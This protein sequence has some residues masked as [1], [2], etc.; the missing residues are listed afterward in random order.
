MTDTPTTPEQHSHFA[1][2]PELLTEEIW[3]SVV[4]AYYGE[5][6]G[7]EPSE[8]ERS[9]VSLDH[10][11]TNTDGFRLGSQFSAHS[12]L[13]VRDVRHEGRYLVGFDFRVNS[14]RR[15]DEDPTTVRGQEVESVRRRFLGRIDAVLEASGIAQPIVEE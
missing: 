4:D 8:L 10:A 14:E 11:L 12:K 2:D 9:R 3:S 5:V 13:C 1:I 7:F 15:D 6:L